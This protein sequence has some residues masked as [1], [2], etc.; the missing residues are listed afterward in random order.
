MSQGVSAADG[1]S[2][3]S[4][5]GLRKLIEDDE[6]PEDLP[7][8]LICLDMDGTILDNDH[9]VSKVTANTLQMLS[10][11]GIT[12]CIATGRSYTS[13]LEYLQ[14][15]LGGLAQPFVPVIAFNGSVC[16]LVSTS[17]WDI[18]HTV[19]RDYIDAESLGPL[20]KLCNDRSSGHTDDVVV[21]QYYDGNTGQVNVA[22][23]VAQT[24]VE[25]DLLK[26][27]ADLTG[28]QQTL[29]ESYESIAQPPVKCL[30]LCNDVDRLIARAA[31][32]LQ[33]GAFH[34]IRGSPYPFFVEF[35]RPGANK[36]SAVEKLVAYLSKL[37]AE[38][39]G[40]KHDDSGSG[41]GS[42]VGG[43]NN[44]TASP[45]TAATASKVYSLECTIAFGD[46]ENDAE[47]L[48]TVGYGVAMLNGRPAAKEAAKAVTALTNDEDGVALYLNE[49]FFV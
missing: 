7:F 15:Y 12:I 16:V 24:D 26:R 21:I 31:A 46:G 45:D 19:F 8:S 17:S 5:D 44:A 38:K 23:S 36:G 39:R 9:K 14:T 32:E 13:V 3:A 48:A 49:I 29:V 6:R 30:A 37:E 43:G 47:M 41:S 42:G 25:K 28:K 1:K 34:V 4:L 10:A 20:L 35:L 18:T 22:K 27:Y 2:A 33:P 11:S 40:G